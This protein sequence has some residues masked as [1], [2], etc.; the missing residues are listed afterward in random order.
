M[1]SLTVDSRL[2]QWIS[3]YGQEATPT[4][5]ILVLNSEP[6]RSKVAPKSKVLEMGLNR[7]YLVKALILEYFIS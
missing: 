2:G 3:V 5:Y 7:F 1:S 6:P 4:P